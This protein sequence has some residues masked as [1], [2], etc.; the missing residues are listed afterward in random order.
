VLVD[1]EPVIASGGR[2]YYTGSVYNPDGML[3][4][5]LTQEHLMIP[6]TF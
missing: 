5:T 4:A 2:A 6:R 1:L 3:V